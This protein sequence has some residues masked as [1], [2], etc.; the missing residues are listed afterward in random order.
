MRWLAADLQGDDAVQFA[1]IVAVDYFVGTVDVPLLAA[2]AFA[3]SFAPSFRTS[4]HL[5]V[6]TFFATSVDLF[7]RSLHPLHSSDET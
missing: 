4:L 1:K 2:R 7:L 6:C 5:F 3:P